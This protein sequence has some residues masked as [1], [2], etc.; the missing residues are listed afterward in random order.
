MAQYIL[1]DRILTNLKLDGNQIRHNGFHAISVCLYYNQTLKNIVWSSEDIEVA[2]RKLAGILVE[3]VA[4]GRTI[5]GIG[6]NTTG[7]ATD[8]PAALVQRVATLP[9]LVG[10]AVPRER[11]LVEFLPRLRRLLGE[12]TADPALL[13]DR[14]RPLCALHG[15]PVTIHVGAERH[16]GLCRG[17]AADGSLVLDTPAGRM[18]FASGSLTDPAAVW[19]GDG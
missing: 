9:D 15:A 16:H 10:A 18:R 5:F 2:G 19:R 4:R 3:T 1:Q 11:I 6:V 14:Y 7:R 12:L 13:S 17:I 8:A